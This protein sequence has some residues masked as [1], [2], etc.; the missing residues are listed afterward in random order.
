MSPDS[1]SRLLKTN[2]KTRHEVGLP[3]NTEEQYKRVA[4]VSS[5]DEQHP[6]HG[7]GIASAQ[8]DACEGVEEQI[9]ADSADLAK[10]SHDKLRV[11]DMTSQQSIKELK[12]GMNNDS[13]NK[14]TQDLLDGIEEPLFYRAIECLRGLHSDDSDDD[15]PS[16]F[17]TDDE[18][19]YKHQ[20][21]DTFITSFQP[22]SAN[23]VPRDISY[24][25]DSHANLSIE[26]AADPKVKTSLTCH[27]CSKGFTGKE[28]FLSSKLRRHI[29]DAHNFTRHT[30]KTCQKSFSRWHNLKVHMSCVHGE[31]RIKKAPSPLTSADKGDTPGRT[32]VSESESGATSVAS[33]WMPTA[34]L[35]SGSPELTR[36]N[37]AL[38]QS[39]WPTPAA[40]PED[41]LWF[42]SQFRTVTGNNQSTTTSQSSGSVSAT[43][44]ITIDG[45]FSAWSAGSGNDGDAGEATFHPSLTDPDGN[46]AWISFPRFDSPAPEWPGD[47]GIDSVMPESSTYPP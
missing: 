15:Q 25:M 2:D 33:Y 26:P 6:I 3:Q 22:T 27:Y 20:D 47:P 45:N 8:Y 18:N 17:D 42:K 5:M 28:Q 43:T 30:C 32:L 23:F 31:D 39:W 40:S 16:C 37:P 35:S 12:S 7:A 4:K 41:T 21:D 38:K 10:A 1:D 36:L 14:W 29:R 24:I 46:H 34:R 19:C 13:I 9:A 44:G 11:E